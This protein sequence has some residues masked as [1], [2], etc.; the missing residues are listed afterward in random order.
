MNIFII[1][2]YFYLIRSQNNQIYKYVLYEK[3]AEMGSVQVFEDLTLLR[4][5]HFFS[6][7]IRHESS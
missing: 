1:T 3:E 4:R 2:A 7:I 5:D 6:K